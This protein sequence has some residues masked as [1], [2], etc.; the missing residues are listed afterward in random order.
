MLLKFHL[1]RAMHFSILVVVLNSVLMKVK[2]K[3]RKNKQLKKKIRL[4]REPVITLT[5]LEP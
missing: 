1:C 2:Q 4:M 5:K 3:E